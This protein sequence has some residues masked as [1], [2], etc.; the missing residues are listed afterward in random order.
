MYV[1]LLISNKIWSSPAI[2]PAVFFILALKNTFFLVE[3]NT[4]FC[5]ISSVGISFSHAYG[6]SNRNRVGQI[7]L[8]ISYSHFNQELSVQTSLNICIEGMA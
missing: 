7:G 4:T 6:H 2:N 1:F 5:L 3:E 8:K